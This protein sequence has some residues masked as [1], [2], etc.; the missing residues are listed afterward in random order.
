M[1]EYSTNWDKLENNKN[2]LEFVDIVLQ[3]RKTL[4]NILKSF[5]LKFIVNDNK[6]RILDLGTGDGILVKNLYSIDQNIEFVVTDGSQDM[7]D[8]AKENLKGIN[9]IKYIHITFE[10]IIENRFKENFFDFI[11]SSFA[12]HHLLLDQKRALFKCLFNLINPGGYFINID[13]V[14]NNDIKYT[15]WY[16]DLWKEW[17][18]RFQK[19]NNTNTK[20]EDIPHK[21]PEKPENHYDPL[22]KQLQ[23][24]KEAGFTEVNCHYKYGLYAI[25]GGL[26]K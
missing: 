2:Y 26:K 23:F 12:I 3:D 1:N 18:E 21:A 16:L 9:N 11:V 22:D 14:T 20:C 13:T 24:L 10:E 15:K 6:K 25:Y 5:F 17:I 7:L 19:E 4:L 8:K